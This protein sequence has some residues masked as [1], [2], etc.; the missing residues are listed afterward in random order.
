MNLRARLGERFADVWTLLSDTDRFLSRAR[1]LE[2]YQSRLRDWRTRLTE[3]RGDSEK[4][5]AVREEIVAVR[6]ALRDEGWELRLGSVDVV[7]RGFRSDD[8]MAHGF[9]RMVISLH[10]DGGINYITG[11]ENHIELAED[12]RRNLQTRR[13]GGMTE[14]HY[15]WYRVGHGLIEF[16]GAD[17][18]TRDDFEHFRQVVEERKSDIVRAMRGLG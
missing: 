17:S 9:K 15:L 18:E 5:K 8:A 11:S 10:A 1:L 13:I 14:A 16:A 2:R 12:L 4:T 7:A 6:K 3:A